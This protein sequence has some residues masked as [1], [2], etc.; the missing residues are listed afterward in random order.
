MSKPVTKED[1]TRLLHYLEAR[2]PELRNVP[3]GDWSGG[4]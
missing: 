3:R 1:W 4:E 2:Y